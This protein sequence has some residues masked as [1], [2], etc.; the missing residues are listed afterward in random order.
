MSGGGVFPQ[1]QP[2][3][4]ALGIATFPVEITPDTKKPAV[5]NY[6][7][8]GLR[9]SAKLAAATRFAGYDALGFMA[10]PR[11]GITVVDMDESDPKILEDGERL[12]GPSPLVWQTGGGRFAAAYKFNGET[13]QIGPIH[14]M[15]IDI[16]GGGFV[17]APPSQGAK[18]RYEIIRGSLDDLRR[19]PTAQI[20]ATAPERR[21]PNGLEHGRRNTSLFTYCLRCAPSCDDFE[22]LLDVARTLNMEFMEPLP[23]VEIVKTATSAWRY[24]VTGRNWAGRKARASTDREEILAM[25][26]DPAAAMLLMLLR[27]SHPLPDDRFAVDQI[28][29]AKLLSWDRKTVHA[30]IESLIACGRLKRIHFG[31]GKNDPHLYV[32]CWPA[33][34]GKKRT[35]YN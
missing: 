1:W 20:P 7:R 4:A 3:Y 10:G 15:P 24:Q 33:T 17:V 14:G 5:S 6:D 2:R 18:R 34:V 26:R 22:V 32:L 29:T 13:R 16:L 28:K 21:P 12:F 8:V 19:L 11:S 35:Q 9:A 31:S 27:V 25:S 30:K 23:D